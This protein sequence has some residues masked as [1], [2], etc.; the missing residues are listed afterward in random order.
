[1]LNRRPGLYL[2]AAKKRAFLSDCQFNS[3]FSPVE[4]ITFTNRCEREQILT[5]YLI[6]ITSSNFEVQEQTKRKDPN[7]EDPASIDMAHSPAQGRR[8]APPWQAMTA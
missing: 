8:H 4:K 7:K 1:M 6:P 5:T 3:V 2:L